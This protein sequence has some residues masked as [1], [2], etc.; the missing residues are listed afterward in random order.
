MKKNNYSIFDF[1]YKEENDILSEFN[2]TDLLKLFVLLDEYYLELR[3]SLCLDKNDTFGLELEFEHAKRE[4]ISNFLIEYNLVKSWSLKDDVSLN[5]V[6]GAEITSPILRDDKCSYEEL[7]TICNMLKSFSKNGKY[8]GGHIHVGTQVLGDKLQ[9]W[10]N[11]IKIWS[12]YE[13][14]IFRFSYGEYL[15]ERPYINVYAYPVSNN[16]YRDY[17]NYNN[18]YC[19]IDEFIQRIP[20]S[21]IQAVEFN[22]VKNFNKITYKNTIEFRC[23]NGSINPVIWQNNVN[24]FVKLL[25]YCKSE[26]FNDDIIDRRR[27]INKDRYN[28]LYWYREIYI[29]QALEFVDMIFDNNLDKIY[30]LKQYLKGFKIGTKEFKKGKRLTMER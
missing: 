3:N 7:K 15:T 16:L 24:L 12:V 27:N 28:D 21:N 18:Y 2:G 20:H 25:S 9:S 26:R 4:K 6:N 8:C 5:E 14:I 13:N 1:I 17:L 19:S 29:E 30:F 22:N 11:F 23:P 10:K